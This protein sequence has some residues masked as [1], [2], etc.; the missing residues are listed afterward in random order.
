MSKTAHRR[1]FVA[2][3]AMAISRFLSAH[4]VLNVLVISTYPLFS[5]WAR[6]EYPRSVSML[7]G[8]EKQTAMTLLAMCGVKFIRRVNMDSWL[9]DVFMYSKSGILMLAWMMDQRIF[10]WYGVMYAMLFL[11][12]RKP[13]YKG[14]SRIEWLNPAT[15]KRRVIERSGDEANTTWIVEFYA[16]WSPPCVNLEPTY[17]A[18]SCKY[19]SENL[20]FAKL[21]LMRWPKTGEEYG[22]NVSGTSKQLPTLILFEK[23]VEVVRVPHMYKDGRIARARLRKEDLIAAFSLDDRKKKETI[24]AMLEKPKSIAEKKKD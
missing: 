6:H 13:E 1:H 7:E 2:R 21:D 22:I 18:L 10:S 15:L 8:W 24:K 14:P 23:G 4:Y 16:S 17:A 11:Y 12:V 3:S 9:S 20:K 19:G 5:L